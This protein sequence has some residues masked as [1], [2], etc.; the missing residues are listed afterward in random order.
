MK[1]TFQITEQ[2]KKEILEQHNFFKKV[3]QSKSEVKRLI[4]NEQTTPITGGGIEFLKAARDAGCKIA[5][6]AVLKSAPGKPTILYKK[7]DYNSEKG[8]FKIGD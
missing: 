3:L 2:E 7:A 1:K 8:Y 5:K 6:G 4:V